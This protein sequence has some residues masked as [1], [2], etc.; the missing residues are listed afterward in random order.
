MHQPHFDRSR[1]V[2]FSAYMGPKATTEDGFERTFGVN[3]LGHFYLTNLLQDKLK[4]G[5]PSRV[6]NVVSDSYV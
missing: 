1:P 3:Y 4:R 2:H 6:I 5:A